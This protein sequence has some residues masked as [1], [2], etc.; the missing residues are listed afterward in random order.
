MF[1][2]V[3]FFVLGTIVGSFLNVVIL[4][5]GRE[6][7]S[8]RSECFSCGKKLHWYELLPILSFLFLGGR[9]LSCKS[10]ISWQY[11][12][13]ELGTG[14]LFLFT[15]I[16]NR[17]L[18]SASAGLILLLIDL[19]AI[20]TLVVI[21][22]YDLKHKII[23]DGAVY[24]F[25]IVS[26]IKFFIF[27]LSLAN[28]YGLLFVFLFIF[29]IWFFSH[30]A[31]MGFGDVKLALG[32]GAFLPVASSISAITIGFWAGAF[33]SIIILLLQ[34]FPSLK[35][36]SK[37]LTIKSEIPFGP[38]LVIGIL[39]AYFFGFDIFGIGLLL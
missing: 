22:V 25:I 27:N 26:L 37:T 12:L 13:V 8:G 35:I 36:A 5:S 34:R 3:F 14:L 19:V 15:F 2:N 33:L 23:P 20:S 17:A 32:I 29:S 6:Y 28:F 1:L 10:R 7:L 11:P 31:W 9:C 24:T 4:R 38:F 21:F 30:G 18:L 16:I 39:T